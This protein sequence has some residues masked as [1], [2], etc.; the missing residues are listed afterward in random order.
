MQKLFVNT[1][2]G[3]RGNPGP[4]GV[5]VVVSDT[6]EKTVAEFSEYIG[7][8][9]NNAAE[10]KALILGL[11]KLTDFRFDEAEFRLDSELVVKQMNGEYKVKEA[12]LKPLYQ[13]AQ[14]LMFFKPIKITHVP[15]AKNQEADTLVNKAIDS[16]L[17][18]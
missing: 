15:R 12:G 5:G 13:K 9:T 18:S 11:E 2:G 7:E 6:N 17:N 16:H 10:Y 8:A 4:A 3:A 14:E 1:D